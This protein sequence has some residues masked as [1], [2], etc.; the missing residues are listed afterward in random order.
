MLVQ[1]G[2]ESGVKKIDKKSV[3]VW[4][5][6]GIASDRADEEPGY[7][8]YTGNTPEQKLSPHMHIEDFTG[9]AVTGVTGVTGGFEEG[10]L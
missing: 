6:V 1:R 5:G 3:R 4:K 10:V 2:A 8:R 7:T 9:N